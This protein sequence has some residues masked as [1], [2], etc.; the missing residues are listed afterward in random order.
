MRYVV[1]KIDRL[2]NPWVVW[3]NHQDV[4]ELNCEKEAQARRYAK[5]LNEE[6]AAELEDKVYE[7]GF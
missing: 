4:V 2:Y 3:D 1:K 6:W 5:Q 7:S